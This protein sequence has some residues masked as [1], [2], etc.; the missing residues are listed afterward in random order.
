[1]LNTLA[2]IGPETLPIVFVIILLLFGADKIP[3][4]MRGVGK[5]VGE[6]QRHKEELMKSLQDVTK[7]HD[8]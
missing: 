3:E 2:M 8:A 7:D 1:M 4:L 5:G 6:M